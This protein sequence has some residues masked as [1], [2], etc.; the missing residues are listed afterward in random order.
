MN[1]NSLITQFDYDIANP[2]DLA[3]LLEQIFLYHD[4]R[5]RD[6]GPLLVAQGVIKKYEESIRRRAA[7]ELHT[8]V[9]GRCVELRSTMDQLGELLRQLEKDSSKVDV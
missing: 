2:H 1:I 6:G 3:V 8:R 7:P 4:S 9:K 5:S